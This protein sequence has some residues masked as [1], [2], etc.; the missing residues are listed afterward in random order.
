MQQADH[1]H[2]LFD[3]GAEFGDDARH[4]DAAGLEVAAARVENGFEFLDEVTS[5]PLRNTADMMRVRATIH[6]KWSMFFELMNTS[7][8]RRSSCSV[9]WLSTMSLIVT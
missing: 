8:G 7:N 1:L 5:S 6:W 9:P 3:D 4:V 2:V